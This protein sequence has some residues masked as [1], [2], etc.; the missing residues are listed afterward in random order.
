[1]AK[2]AIL[3]FYS[4]FI[5]RGVENFAY[6]VARRLAKK[7]R[8]T[9]F[10]AGTSHVWYQKL[11][12]KP[13]RFKV[14]TIKT[15]TS[16]P[17]NSIRL[18]GKLYLDW[19][20]VKI[21]IFTLKALPK[22]FKGK[23]DL[24]ILLNGGWQI[25]VYRIISKLTGAKILVSGHAGIGADDAWN[26]LWRPDIFVALTTPQI[27]WA[28]KLAP[29]VKTLVIPNG[30]DLARFNPKVQAA[31]LPLPKPIVICASAL[32]PYKRVD[33]TIKAVAKS[34]SFSLLVLG[35]GEMRGIIDSLGKR[36][37]GKRY[38][39]L[40]VPY[41]EIPAYYR[42]G[43]VFTLASK[44]EAFGTS[45]IEAMACNLPVV[46]VSDDARSE[47]VGRAGILTD[48]T[49]IDQYAKDLLLAAST[50]YRNIPYDQAAK[51]S[52]N[53]IA[54]RYQTL[55]EDVLFKR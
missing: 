7:H 47:I 48:V 24:I 44:T 40:L 2:I 16:Y 34:K 36:L 5:E 25:V 14:I 3:S 55:I 6:E 37:L 42:A 32:V 15:F 28:Q 51:F 49:N 46:T 1:M 27:H 52:W 13:E 22:I 17:K 38:L 11:D 54:Q 31:A 43:Q 21:L 20:S 30:V 29:E 45:Y 50:N 53:K 4:G 23:Y 19:W 35:D 41:S 33:L 39:R 26:L 8:I 12:L 18:F 10:Q 9:I